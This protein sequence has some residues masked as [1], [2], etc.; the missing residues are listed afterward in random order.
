[1][2][3][4]EICELLSTEFL[5]GAALDIDDEIL[6]SGRLDSLGVMT[7]V[8]LLE[9]RI[10]KAIPPEDIVLEHFSSASAIAAYLQAR[11]A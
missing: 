1:M 3:A 10:G 11:A 4:S 9:A 6:I 2:T 5:D 8:T 7:L